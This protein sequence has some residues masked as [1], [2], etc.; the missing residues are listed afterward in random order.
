LPSFGQTEKDAIKTEEEHNEIIGIIEIMPRFVGCEHITDSDSKRSKCAQEKLLQYVYKNLQ[1]PELARK[2]NIEGMVVSQFV[3]DTTG[4]IQDIKV[5]RDIGG[6]CDQA[7]IDV[8]EKMNQ[9]L[10]PPFI[11]GYQRGIKVKVMY[12]FP[13]KFKLEKDKK[14]KKGKKKRNKK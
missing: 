6:G 7:V 2:N 9:E 8:F 10:N 14:S 4:M 1:Y 13:V 3:I 12:T 5:V 11:P